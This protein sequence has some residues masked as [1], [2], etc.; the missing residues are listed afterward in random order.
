MNYGKQHV[1]VAGFAQFPKGNPVHELYKVMGC[2][3][4]IDV[5]DDIVVEA[6][7]TFVTDTPKNFLSSLIKGQSVKNG[8]A[9]I[10]KEVERRVH[11][12]GQKA[13]I[14]S[15]IAAY[16]RYCELKEKYGSRLS[17]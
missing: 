10:V 8:I 12:P 1:L 9:H 15:L 3:L 2:I 13:V 5:K 4:I 11:I 6:T 7:F 16:E 14:Q 17:Y